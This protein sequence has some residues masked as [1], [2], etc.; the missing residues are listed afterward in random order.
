MKYVQLQEQPIVASRFMTNLTI[1][2][3]EQIRQH[4]TLLKNCK[5]VEL[6]H[7]LYQKAYTYLLKNKT[8][9]T[10]LKKEWSINMN[11]FK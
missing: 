4:L 11:L 6:I 2:V 7:M 10:K 9:K 5:N 1:Y 3:T 8:V